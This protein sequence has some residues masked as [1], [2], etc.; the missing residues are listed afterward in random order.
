MNPPAKGSLHAVT[1]DNDGWPANG[2]PGDDTLQTLTSRPAPAPA[3]A[4]PQPAATAMQTAVDKS[5]AL[6]QT[7]RPVAAYMADDAVREIAIPRPGDVFLKIR[8]KWQYREAPEL[9]FKYLQ[10]LAAALASYNRMGFSPIMSLKLPD[11]ERGQV[12]QPPAL[13]DGS[14]SINIRKHSATVKTLEDLAAEGAFD[15]YD[16]SRQD[17]RREEDEKLLA[18]LAA[19]DLVGFLR[20]AVQ[21]RRN[22]A[23]G[24]KNGS[25][26][27]TFARSLIELI[28]TEERL[29]TI[30]D[31][32]ELYLP[33]HRNRVH[34]IF[35]TQ[36]D[37]VVTATACVAACMRMS[38]DRIFLS[39]L[40][41]PEAWEY[42]QGLNT[43][44][45]GSVT[46]THANSAR[47]VFFRLALL[48]KQSPAG[49]QIDITLLERY[50]YST[51]DITLYYSDFKL[52]DVYFDPERAQLR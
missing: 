4:R 12:V 30:E 27:T 22:I 20:Y 15:S 17:K 34:L 5:I 14:L 32:H 29:I 48:V 26:K 47:D 45:P 52:V 35:S 11:G 42:L 19:R 21:V 51:I 36:A 8:G 43:G 50:L 24:G 6:R 39:E 23:V 10:G 3:P 41:G 46:T 18:L 31:V 33:N 49:Q 37:A 9:H 40:R 44:H 2:L 16:A 1:A 7:M 13:L 38:P 25:G 28:P